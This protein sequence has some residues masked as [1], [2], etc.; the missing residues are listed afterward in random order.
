MWFKVALTFESNTQ[1]P[2]VYRTEFDAKGAS[3]ALS[4]ALREA[5]RAHPGTR[6]DSVCLVLEK[7]NEEA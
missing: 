7:V 5:R 1:A 6:W 4:R 2:K 3:T